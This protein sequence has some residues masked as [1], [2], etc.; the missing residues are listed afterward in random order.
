MPLVILRKCLKCPSFRKCHRNPR[1]PYIERPCL[2]GKL[3]PAAG[4]YYDLIRVPHGHIPVPRVKLW[5]LLPLPVLEFRDYDFF[6]C[7]ECGEPSFFK[8]NYACWNCEDV[9]EYDCGRKAWRA[10]QAR[11]HRRARRIYFRGLV[12]RL[13]YL[14][15]PVLL[16]MGKAWYVR[17]ERKHCSDFQREFLGSPRN[18]HFCMFDSGG[19]E[20]A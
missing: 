19:Q 6:S 18:R 7:P 14:L 15:L 20:V 10:W 2:L 13:E 1:F 4:L 5:A 8:I 11:V 17:S 12:K 16:L 9:L 3:R